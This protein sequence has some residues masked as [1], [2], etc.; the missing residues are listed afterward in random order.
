MPGP[1]ASEINKR[2]QESAGRAEGDVL[3]NVER[4]KK[5]LKKVEIIKHGSPVQAVDFAML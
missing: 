5:R 1:G 4:R 2:R 3:E